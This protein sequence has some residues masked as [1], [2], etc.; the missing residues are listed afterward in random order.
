[1]NAAAGGHTYTPQV[2]LWAAAPAPPPRS[3]RKQPIH[4]PAWPPPSPPQHTALFLGEW[5]TDCQSRSP[6]PQRLMASPRWQRAPPLLRTDHF[7]AELHPASHQTLPWVEVVSFGMTSVMC[8]Q[9]HLCPFSRARAATPLSAHALQPL[10]IKPGLQGLPP[11]SAFL[12]TSPHHSPPTLSPLRSERQKRLD[13][14][15]PRSTV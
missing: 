15:I 7:S 2:L 9:S 3:A 4:L 13:K 5:Y 12:R 1:M 10:Q 11:P 8:N 14:P 6:D